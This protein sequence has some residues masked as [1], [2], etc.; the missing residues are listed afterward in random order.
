VFARDIS[1]AA[2]LETL[3][4]NKAGIRKPLQM[5]QKN[6]NVTHRVMCHIRVATF[7]GI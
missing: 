4:Q 1:G 7:K 6:T 5:P 2:A 3:G